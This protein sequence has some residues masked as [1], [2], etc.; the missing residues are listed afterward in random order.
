[1]KKEFWIR[2]S[3]TF[4]AY[5]ACTNMIVIKYFITKFK[6]YDLLWFM[7]VPDCC[8]FSSVHEALQGSNGKQLLVISSSTEV[9]WKW[10]RSIVSN[11]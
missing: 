9:K 1:M 3:A 10:S 8:M 5:W 2:L 4:L 7:I 11:S 6:E